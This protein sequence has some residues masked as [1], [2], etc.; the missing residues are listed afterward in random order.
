[1]YLLWFEQRYACLQYITF[2][3]HWCKNVY[4]CNKILCLFALKNL[5]PDSIFPAV[6]ADMPAVSL[7]LLCGWQ[8]LF[9]TLTIS[10]HPLA[11]L[12]ALT[13]SSAQF[14]IM[15][16]VIISPPIFLSWPPI[17]KKRKELRKQKK[18]ELFW[19]LININGKMDQ[20]PKIKSVK[21]KSCTKTG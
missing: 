8:Q 5:F 3:A 11:L 7:I 19:K 18:E 16:L 15:M 20:H 13:H 10:S 1:M 21:M 6:F 2:L 14:H 4:F 9:L 12:L 17:R